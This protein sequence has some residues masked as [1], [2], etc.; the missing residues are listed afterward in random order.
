MTLART[1][2]A[3]L[4][5][6]IA[7]AS[8]LALEL[9]C[10]GGSWGLGPVAAV[11]AAPPEAA[12]LSVFVDAGASSMT[13][14][15]DPKA[16]LGALERALIKAGYTVVTNAATPHDVTLA[17]TYSHDASEV[18]DQLKLTA[19]GVVIEAV[20]ATE[21]WNQSW[22][23]LR[24]RTANDLV[25][26]MS[27]SPKTAAFAA[28]LRGQPV[29]APAPA[30][31]ASPQQAATRSDAQP[32]RTFLVGQPQPQSYALIVG[33][34][35]YR[36]VPA[37]TGA[38]RDAERFAELCKTTLGV[39]PE[40]LRLAIEERAT[41]GDIK[42]HLEWLKTNAPS[43][44]RVYF[45][46]S[47]HGAPDASQGTPYILPYD[48]DA[49][50]IAE[51]GI[52]LADA[53]KSLGASK[54]REVL[55]VVD[56]CFSGAGGRSVLPPG[57]RPLV[58]VRDTTPVA[59]VSLFSAASGAEISGPAPGDDGGLFSK[60]VAE[61]LGSGAADI[62]GDGS[63]SLKELYDWVGPR[64]AREAKKDG[65]DQNPSLT[66][67]SGDDPKAFSVAYGLVK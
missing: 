66:S 13:G 28:S 15:E 2:G 54:A 16:Q 30:K 14:E 26:A 63:V 38:K 6:A 47:G 53:L 31:P 65:R 64:V 49:K 46:Y 50:L 43:N 3:A 57:T 34:E 25:N 17:L 32:P 59:R 7:T 12:R 60:L 5:L 35:H 61:G 10:G 20:E 39:K 55:A 22:E 56:S 27:A 33:I 24:T 19:N 21:S 44:S 45:F 1:H 11:Q 58:K 48:G 9:A 4:S 37:A 41:L 18:H 52:P 23:D 29:A 62:D 67:P 40:N 42:K 36:D 8:L 51:T